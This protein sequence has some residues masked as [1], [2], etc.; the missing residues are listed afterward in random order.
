MRLRGRTDALMHARS[1]RRDYYDVLGVPRD[2]EPGQMRRAFHA[3][4]RE[5][6][7]DVATSVEAA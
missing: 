2:A 4:A 3:L 7:P 1:L 5:V 6:H